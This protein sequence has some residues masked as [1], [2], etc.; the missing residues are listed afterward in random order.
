M[1]N[2][3]RAEKYVSRIKRCLTAIKILIITT[4][5][6]LLV[7]V[8]FIAVAAGAQIYSYLTA[9]VLGLCIPMLCAALAFCGALTAILVAKIS[10]KQLKKLGRVESDSKNKSE[11]KGESIE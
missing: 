6:A 8:L 9:A 1:T 10:L 2:E 4:V 11:E 5:A 3:Q 7:L